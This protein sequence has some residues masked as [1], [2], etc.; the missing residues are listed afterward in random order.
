MGK[1]ACESSTALKDF[2][3]QKNISLMDNGNMQEEQL[4]IKHLHLHKRK[5]SQIAKNLLSFT[6]QNSISVLKGDVS[7]VSIS[8]KGICNISDQE[9]KQVPKVMSTISYISP[10]QNP[11]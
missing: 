7:N 2:C 6:E 1:Q 9:E 11:F 4:S 3:G 5:K 10:K 8:L